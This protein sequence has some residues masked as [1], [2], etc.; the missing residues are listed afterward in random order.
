MCLDYIQTELSVVIKL[1]S[2]ICVT[3]EGAPSLVIMLMYL[4]NLSIENGNNL[5]I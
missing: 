5:N 3:V 4:I 1:I 2:E